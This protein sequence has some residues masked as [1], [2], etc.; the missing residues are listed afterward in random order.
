MLTAAVRT[1]QL[2][3]L[4][5]Q[6]VEFLN[7]EFLNVELGGIKDRQYIHNIILR[8]VIAKMVDMVEL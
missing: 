2:H 8:R 3:T 7:V 5:G 6:K 1:K 4:C